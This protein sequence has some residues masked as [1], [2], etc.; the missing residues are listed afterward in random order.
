[1]NIDGQKYHDGCLICRQ[2]DS[3]IRKSLVKTSHGFIHKQCMEGYLVKLSKDN[4]LDNL[5]S[6]RKGV[7]G[8]VNIINLANH[9]ILGLFDMIKN[10]QFPSLKCA[11]YVKLLLNN[12]LNILL[13][14]K[15]ENINSRLQLS[16]RNSNL[17]KRV[18]QD[19]AL[20]LK[21]QMKTQSKPDSQTISSI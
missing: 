5:L 19:L 11:I 16:T 12:S 4:H 13:F 3:A 7:G 2:C 21:P 9:N 18:Y 8:W 6:V 14:R 1:M 15:K 17:R 10:L 20:D